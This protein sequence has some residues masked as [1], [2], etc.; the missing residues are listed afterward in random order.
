MVRL[1][2]DDVPSSMLGN[3]ANSLWC[4]M[5]TI[6]TVGYGDYYPQTYLTRVILFFAAITGIIIAS[7]LI[8]TLST[9]L[10]MELS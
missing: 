4:V 7:L 6:G 8:L 1:S 2:E 5:I 3:F 9:Y 10:A